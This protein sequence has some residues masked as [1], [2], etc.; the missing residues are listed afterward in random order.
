L[1]RIFETIFLLLTLNDLALE[2]SHEDWRVK[3]GR[4]PL[5]IKRFLSMVDPG[6]ESDDILRIPEASSTMSQILEKASAL[7]RQ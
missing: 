1:P 6:E 7:T 5:K 4:S 2:R 3:T